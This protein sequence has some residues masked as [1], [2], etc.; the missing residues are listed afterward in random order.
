MKAVLALCLVLLVIAPAAPALA[1]PA[2]AV[3]TQAAEQAGLAR[4]DEIRDAVR[5]S[6]RTSMRLY[7]PAMIALAALVGSAGFFGRRWLRDRS[8]R[9][10]GLLALLS[11][12]AGAQ[13]VG[14]LGAASGLSKQTLGFGFV[15]AGAGVATA[16]LITAFAAERFAPRVGKAITLASGG[17]LVAVLLIVRDPA[18][19]ALAALAVA[20]AIAAG[21][22]AHGAMRGRKG[23][24][25]IALAIAAFALALLL[26]P[27][28]DATSVLPISAVVA[29]LLAVQ[30]AALVQREREAQDLRRHAEALQRELEAARRPGRAD[31][32]LAV[33]VRNGKRLVQL[34]DIDAIRA[35]DDYCELVLNR[36]DRLLHS[37]TL[38]ALAR[39]LPATFRRVH[40]SVIVN[41]ERIEVL[42]R[43]PSG[44]Y[45]ILTKTG[46]VLPVGRQYLAGARAA[47]EPG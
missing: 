8:D 21:L 47:V 30:M 43:R 6:M 7:V 38:E 25:S 20:A 40:R 9:G 10:A 28:G 17:L 46:E 32:I 12:A 2:P 4:R 14:G 33:K 24:V 41:L 37:A 5:E 34:S 22:A 13:L 36:G 11:I 42:R 19:K 16:L 27:A 35:A 29:T 45:E 3:S 26:R 44:G 18:G 31:E 15:I 39:E 23:A 1:Q